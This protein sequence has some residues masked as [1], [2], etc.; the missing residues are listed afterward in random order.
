MMPNFK[1][2]IGEK[3]EVIMTDKQIIETLRNIK[4]YCKEDTCEG[5]KFNTSYREC[6]IQNIIH[7]LNGDPAY[8]EIEKI[9]RIINETD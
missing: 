3:R 1:A 4:K 5:C 8:W 9:E 2:S 7:L 6:Q